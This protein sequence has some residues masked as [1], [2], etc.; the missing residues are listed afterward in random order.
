[1]TWYRHLL[2]FAIALPGAANADTDA[3]VEERAQ[4]TTRPPLPS[5]RIVAAARR[6][7][8]IA[9]DGRLDEKAWEAAEVQGDFIQREPH[10]GK[11]PAFVTEFRVLYDDS[12]LYVAVRAR[13]PE[14]GLIRGLLTRRDVDSSSDWVSLKIDSYHDRRTAFGFSLNPAGVQRDVLHFN[15]VEQDPSWDAVWES[16]A[17]VDG[18]GWVAEL[19]IPYNQLR[20]AS[21]PDQTWGLQVLRRVQ[22]TQELSSWSPW[23]LEASQEVSL[24]GTLVGIRGIGPARRIEILPYLVFG[25][26]MY[27]SDPVNQSPDLLVSGGLDAKV[28]LGSNFTLSGTINPDF[29]QVEADP[30]QVN[31]SALE[32]FFVEKRPFFLEGTD[33]FRFSLGQGDGDGSVETLFYTRRI[34]APPHDEPDADHIEQPEVTT[35]Y[36]AAKLSGKTSNGWSI[37]LLDAVTGQEE[38]T[39]MLGDVT[40]R[41]VVEPLTNYAV[42][43]VKKDMRDGRTNAGG[44]LTAVNRSLEGVKLDWLHDQAY[45]GALEIWH[46]FWDD[47]WNADARVA[48]SWVHGAPEA[49]D[50]TQR[51]SARYYQRPDADHVDYDPTRTSLSGAAML[52]QFGKSAGGNWRFATGGDGR[53]PG[54]EANDLG[55][56]RQADYYVQWWWAQYRDDQP[57]GLLRQ[58]IVNHNLWRVWDTS[59]LHVSTGGNFNGSLSFLNY[60]GVGGG[61]GVNWN[62]WDPGGLRGGPNLRVDPN[63][64]LW[65]NAWS[66]TRKPVR[67]NLNGSYQWSPATGSKSAGLNAFLLVEARSN[68]ELSAGPSV[69]WQINDSQYVDEV[70][71]AMGQPHYLMARIRQVT[72]AL[73]VRASYTFTPELSLQLY[74]QPFVAAGRYSEYKEATDPRAADY[75]DRFRVFTDFTDMDGIR[76][77]DTDGDGATDFSFGLADFNVREL[78]SNLVAR[79]EYR[80]GSTLFFIWSHGR[81]SD[82]SDGRFRPADDLAELADEPGEHILLAKLTYWLGL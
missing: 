33:I 68:L 43:R 30:S 14:P 31:L 6:S 41:P 78:R 75:Q 50:E 79:W 70:S 35:I 26:G 76:S 80:P 20:F 38:A 47:K 3:A 1:M 12:A 73:T 21:R 28:G 81:T 44:A 61:G 77:V 2:L 62:R 64:P 34:G 57:G 67:G 36:G 39:V 19:R 10:P 15:D 51:S 24:Y 18:E 52:W 63:Y 25:A 48:G 72:T 60:W 13:D 56:Q 16:A 65:W 55:F 29:G 22:R 74:A 59:P 37:G 69:F 27:R 23:P 5:A 58:W 49:I 9:V 32:T 7:G 82:V 8:A 45:T 40:T 53:T 11:A 42:A 54:F 71:D 17:G 66:D 4:A 46:R